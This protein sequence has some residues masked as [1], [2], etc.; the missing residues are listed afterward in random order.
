MPISSEIGL[1]LQLFVEN[2]GRINF[3]IADDMKGLLGDVYLNGDVLKNWVMTTYPFEDYEPIET[4]IAAYH[5]KA[6]ILYSA[7]YSRNYLRTGPTLFHGEF[8][9]GDDTLYDTYIDTTGWGKGVMFIN[10]FN[11]GRYWPIVGPQITLYVPK[12]VLKTGKNT[13]VLL[14]LQIAPSSGQL[15][16][17][18]KPKLDD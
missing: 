1:K 11:L 3:N 15:R 14:E 7:E 5:K 9:L 8:E 6:R 2:Q 4:A 17:T 10:G 13:V 18:D 16:F 12:E